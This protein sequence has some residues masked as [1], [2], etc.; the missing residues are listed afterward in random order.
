MYQ[1]CTCFLFFLTYFYIDYYN[2]IYM[3]YS[4]SAMF[5]I[6][7]LCISLLSCSRKASNYK[8]LISSYKNV[9]CSTMS[10]TNTSMKERQKGL[11]QLDSIKNEFKEAMK[12]LKQEEKD[13][14]NQMIF[15]V[16]K[17]VSQGNC[18]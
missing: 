9:L 3:R 12:R 10:S 4:L 5:C 14:F 2:F 6:C 1:L 16:E 11:V 8:Q 17:E 15:N 13:K 18:N 7:T